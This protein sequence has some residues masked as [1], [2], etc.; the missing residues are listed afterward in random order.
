[1]SS[2]AAW[3]LYG[4]CPGGASTR[5]RSATRSPAARPVQPPRLLVAPG[6]PCRVPARMRAVSTPPGAWPVPQCRSV[7]VCWSCQGRAPNPR[8]FGLQHE[9]R[10]GR[11][12]P[13][14]KPPGPCRQPRPLNGPDSDARCQATPAIAHSRRIR[15]Q[16]VNDRIGFWLTKVVA[17]LSR[18]MHAPLTHHCFL[19]GG[20]GQ[21]RP[22][23]RNSASKFLSDRT[24]DGVPDPI[25]IFL[26]GSGGTNLGCPFAVRPT[27]HPCSRAA[28]SMSRM[29]I[30]FVPRYR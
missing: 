17:A 26:A 5:G 29:S 8:R 23:R 12:T 15:G 24:S 20:Q 18:N 27:C 7:R 28:R 11:D 6:N 21:T 9:R 16:S 10:P 4:A 25:T 2:S 19:P 3:R 30:A 13:C 14:Q 22:C 1:M